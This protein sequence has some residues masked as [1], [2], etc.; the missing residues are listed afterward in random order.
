MQKTKAV[1]FEALLVALCGGVFGLVANAVSPLGLRLSRNY[2]PGTGIA[3]ANSHPTNGTAVATS[4][5]PLTATLQRLHEHGLQT[6]SS[7]EVRQLFT[8]NRYEQGLF[9]FV[10]A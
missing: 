9:V 10:D 2:F 5:D 1:I 4:A 7:N 6:V 8:D 3:A